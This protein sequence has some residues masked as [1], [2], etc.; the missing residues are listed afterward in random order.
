[1]Y[2]YDRDGVTISHREADTEFPFEL[3]EVR[4][5][6]AVSDPI[7]MTIGGIGIDIFLD[8]DGR[9]AG[10]NIIPVPVTPS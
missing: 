6:V 7:H 10:V 1:M 8:E 4:I 3:V 9:P 2:T 5:G